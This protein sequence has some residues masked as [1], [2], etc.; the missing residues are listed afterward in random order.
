MLIH[1][2][3][4][5]FTI[6]DQLDLEFSDG[7]TVI[8]GET[9]TGKSIMLDALGMA[10]GDRS[11]S[12]VL[13]HRKERAEI[14]ATF[15]ICANAQV[16]EWLRARDLIED[17][18]DDCILRRVISKDGRS[19]GYINGHP[20]TVNDLRVLGDMLIDIHSQHEHQSL[21]IGETQRR[22]L[23]EFGANTDLAHSVADLFSAW[24]ARQRELND[25]SSATE[26]QSARLQLLTYQAAELQELAIG[27]GEHGELEVELKR[28]SSAETSLAS[29]QQALA[30]ISADEEPITAQL[31][32]ALSLLRDLEND[33]LKNTIELLTTSHI[34]LEE[35]GSDLGR[36][37]ENF[38]IDPARLKQV[39]ERLGKI[40]EISRKHR[41]TPAEL[42]AL[43]GRIS[44]ELDELGN[45]DAT[46]DAL[47][48]N[49]EQL[50]SEYFAEAE[51]LDRARTK[52]ARTFEKQV[53]A[54]LKSLGMPAGQF[55]I[56]LMPIDTSQPTAHGLSNTEFR[57]CTNPGQAARP[58]NKIASG[59][60]LSR[61]S[62]AIQVI[63]ANTSHIP[64][65]VFDEVDVGIGGGVAEVVGTLL[66]KLAAKGQILCVT[67]LPQV[68]AQGHQHLHVSKATRGKTTETHVVLLD[69]AAKVS[70][71]ARMLGGLEI[72][73][74]S[75]AHA[76]E[77]FESAQS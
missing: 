77:M 6:V 23:D 16:Q 17:E 69:A 27:E 26:E 31:S 33:D 20:S 49:V 35:A 5:N 39:E 74:Q 59:G 12:G 58:L 32:R 28:L 15:D 41:T 51:E 57:I 67:H 30:I 19:R 29:C 10:L 53:T 73:D 14:N 68:A 7:M 60:E 22:L 4:S 8:T 66:R 13:G 21:L 2:S 47:E 54:Q 44:A 71:I 36:Y 42:H 72:T 46:M 24:Q 64:T 1:L 55:E 76:Q 70:E 43:A 63:V 25:L 11:D 61:I 37:V 3:I 62:L 50:R 38:E 48:E 75:M 52:A 65:L 56:K 18:S 9:G 34:Q 45:V 40:Y